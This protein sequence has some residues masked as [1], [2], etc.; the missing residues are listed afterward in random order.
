MQSLV[1]RLHLLVFGVTT[2]MAGVVIAHVPANFAFPAHWR[3]SAADI[4]WPRDVAIAVAPVVQAALLVAFYGLGRLLTKNHFAK[5]QHIF[6]PLLTVALCTAAACQL[7]LVFLAI[8]S[9]LDL[10]RVTAFG[11]AA[12]LLVFAAVIFD[13]ER[14]TYAGLRMPWPIRSERTW[15]I[16]HVLTA[17]ASVAT[18]LLLAWFSWTDAGPA[19]LV[20]VMA[21]TLLVL[22]LTAGLA[23]LALRSLR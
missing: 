1:T 22:P 9:D 16:V 19:V 8:G 2:V 3:G 10:F 12:T 18:A 6:D 21:G 14:H 4:L 5:T 11:L 23:T 7:A 20:G 17:A 13:A 15:R